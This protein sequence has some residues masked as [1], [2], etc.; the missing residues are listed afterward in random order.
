MDTR[1]VDPNRDKDIVPL[2]RQKMS[3]G[4]C[5]RAAF[6]QILLSGVMR[7]DAGFHTRCTKAL[8]ATGASRMAELWEAL[9]AEAM[10]TVVVRR[11]PPSSARAAR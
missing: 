7:Q 9:D 6:F 8:Q 1:P 4:L 3:Q 10:R 5:A 11:M 2:L